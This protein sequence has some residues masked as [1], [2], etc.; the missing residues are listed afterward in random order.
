MNS[1]FSYYFFFAVTL[2][3]SSIKCLTLFC[4]LI[5][6]LFV[7]LWLLVLIT[8]AHL[9]WLEVG[10]E[11]LLGGCS[12]FSFCL[13]DLCRVLISLALGPRRLI[14]A[15]L[16]SLAHCLG[17][18]DGRL[19]PSLEDRRKYW[20]IGLP[21]SSIL[22]LSSWFGLWWWCSTYSQNSWLDN[23]LLWLLLFL[24]S[25]NCSISSPFWIEE[26]H[27]FPILIAS[28]TFIIPG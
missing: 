25:C 16:D 28:G 18:S 23:P 14:S 9:W 24:V 1:F 12:G 3:H 19:L 27:G 5:F 17:S 7:P 13:P 6:V 15:S 2:C 22:P 21:F 11:E 20:N 10:Q 4:L 26:G 8:V